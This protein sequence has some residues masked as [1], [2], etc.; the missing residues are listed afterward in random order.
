MD[1]I[2]ISLG[3]PL[4]SGISGSCDNTVF[5]FLRN[6]QTSSM[7]LHHFTFPL[8]F[9]HPCQHLL[10]S[11]VLILAAPVSMMWYLFVVIMS[12]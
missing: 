1:M 5:K 12:S 7:W 2:F 10:L 9:S 8:D 3:Y 4:R 11:V 6:C